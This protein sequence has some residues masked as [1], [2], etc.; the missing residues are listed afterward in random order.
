MNQGATCENCENC[1]LLDFG[2]SNWTVE[3]TTVICMEQAHPD[4]EFDRYYGTDERLKFAETCPKYVNGEPDS[5]DVDGMTWEELSEKAK[6][7]IYNHGTM[8]YGV[9]YP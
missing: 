5:L 3:G 6:A 7:F 9:K 1:L 8:P 4:L 2:Y